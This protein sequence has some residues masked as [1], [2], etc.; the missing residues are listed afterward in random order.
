[1]F[2]LCICLGLW[3]CGC[4]FWGSM[5]LF[6]R[7]VGLM[8]RIRPSHGRGRGS[9]PRRR[10]PSLCLAFCVLR[11]VFCVLR[12]A[13][14]VLRERMATAGEP[15]TNRLTNRLACVLLSVVG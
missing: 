15:R 10:T 3:F 14:Y 13:F 2:L 12:L 4:S 9:I 7:A 1:M 8:V 5:R 11:V 6:W